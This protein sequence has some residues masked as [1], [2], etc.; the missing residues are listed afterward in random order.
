MRVQ[1]FRLKFQMTLVK[2]LKDAFY[3]WKYFHLPQRKLH[4]LAWHLQNEEIKS[5]E[6]S[7]A[8]IRHLNALNNKRIK[9]QK[10]I[11][12]ISKYNNTCKRCKGNCCL[13]DYNHFNAIDFAVRKYSNNLLND[14]GRI[15]EQNK[16]LDNYFALRN[17]L[18]YFFAIL[19]LFEFTELSRSNTRCP[20]LTEKGCILSY[21]DRPIHCVVFT[22]RA[23]RESLRNDEFTKLACLSKELQSIA[24]EIFRLCKTHARYHKILFQ[25]WMCI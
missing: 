16:L 5:A 14:Y 1:E 8:V 24:Y 17:H 13:G 6:F 7:P 2:P 11:G 9:I 21:K 23:F 18:K 10:E 22:C 20:N 4:I 19:G 12:N 15:S 3:S 25:Y